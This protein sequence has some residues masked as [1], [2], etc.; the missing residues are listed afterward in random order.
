[1]SRVLVQVSPTGE[2][3]HLLAH[4]TTT[5]GLQSLDPGRRSEPLSYYYRTGPVGQ[6]FQQR[7]RMGGN[8]KVAVVGLGAG[9]LAAYSR[10]GEQWDFYEIDPVVVDIAQDPRYFTF[11]RDMKASHRIVPGDGRLMLAKAPDRFY[12]L[13]VVDAFS[14][15][16]IPVHLLTIEAMRVYFSKIADGGFLA[17]NI[18]SRYLRLEQVVGEVAA[19][20]ELECIASFNTQ[21]SPEEID[22]GKTAS[23]WL[24]LGRKQG[25]IA[26]LSSSPG[27][28]RLQPTGK[29]S[30][31]WTDSYSNILGA[32]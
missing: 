22:R 23:K 8:L 12:N 30:R 6:V 26:F 21:L 7:D 24:A 25:D 27:W 16:S 15:D 32:L 2:R 4:G 3:F 18:S 10:S 17:F 19:Q 31:V 11:L 9:G 20:A 1:M 29:R 5:H 28:F 13:I 14:S